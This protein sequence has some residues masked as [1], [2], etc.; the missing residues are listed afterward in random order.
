L[1]RE[2]IGQIEPARDKAQ[3]WR[4]A[5]AGLSRR[6]PVCNDNTLEEGGIIALIGPT[7]AGKTTTA[8]KLAA[9][10]S[11]RH[12]ASKVAF[13]TTDNYRIGAHDQ[14]R[15]YAKILNIPMRVAADSMQLQDCLQGLADRKL[16]IIDTAGM[17]QRDQALQDQLGMLE[18]AS[19]KIRSF[20][21]LP[22]TTGTRVMDEILQ[23]YLP[24][25]PYACI[26]TKVDE[27]TGFGGILDLLIRHK[28]PLAYYSEGQCVPEDLAVVQAQSLVSLCVSLAGKAAPLAEPLPTDTFS[29][30]DI[31]YV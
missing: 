16:V 12:G 29:G 22:S 21:V 9:R 19:R 11:V 31:V 26:L 3:A 25:K 5:L 15:T 17:S 28:L 6:L 20:L 18:T 4:H 7:G 8:A 24:V 27:S 23:R 30:Q 14:L 1:C 2:I 13:I 10:F